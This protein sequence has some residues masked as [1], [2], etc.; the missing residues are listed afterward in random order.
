M[1]VDLQRIEDLMTSQPGI[2]AAAAC[3]WQPSR[4]ESHVEHNTYIE[5]NRFA[6]GLLQAAVRATE[7]RASRSA[8]VDMLAAYLVL[9][10]TATSLPAE[11]E[12][13]EQSL[14][15]CRL[16]LAPGAVPSHFQ[17][18]EHL[19]TTQSG[20]LDRSRLPQ[21]PNLQARGAPLKL[22]VVT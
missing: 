2:A 15:L 12:A 22:L 16:N 8:D 13:I 4:R 5:Q 19:P 7:L 10:A 20:K 9:D 18:L 1:Q 6:F 3:V 17:V 14:A 11:E 21:A